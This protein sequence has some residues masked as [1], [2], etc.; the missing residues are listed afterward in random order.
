MN[1]KI[2]ENEEKKKFL[3][4]QLIL[5]IAIILI[6]AFSYKAFALIKKPSDTARI[7]EGN[8]SLEESTVRLYY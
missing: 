1:K 8:L 7:R 6:A 5:I 4:K 2:D 3:V